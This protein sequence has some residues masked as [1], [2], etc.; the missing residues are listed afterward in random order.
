M[1][2]LKLS[3]TVPPLPPLTFIIWTENN[4]MSNKENE[5]QEV[6]CSNVL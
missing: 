2:T 4:M 1:F 3:K 5:N 6:L